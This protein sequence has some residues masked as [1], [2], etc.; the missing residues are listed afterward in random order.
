MQTNET[1]TPGRVRVVVAYED[2]DA[3]K[4]AQ[5]AC[6]QIAEMAQLDQQMSSDLWKFDMLNLSAMRETATEE[7]SGAD[8]LVLAPHDGLELPGRVLDWLQASLSPPRYP[9]ALLVLLGP[10]ADQGWAPPLTDQMKT[11]AT[12]ANVPCWCIKLEPPNG[13]WAEPV[14]A[15]DVLQQIAQEVFPSS[16][17]TSDPSQPE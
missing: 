11:L 17:E 3:G 1:N 8:L 16:Q 5:H 13:A 6:Q 12:Q 14:Y 2:Y 7:A 15:S 9:K 4:R 10:E